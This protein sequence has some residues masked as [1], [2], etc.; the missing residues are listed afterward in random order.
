MKRFRKIYI[1]IN[2]VCNCKCVN[3]ILSEDSRV[4]HNELSINEIKDLVDS[5]PQIADTN[6]CN[7]AEVSGG[8]PTLH[9]NFI[10]ILQVLKSAKDNGALYK[11]ALLTNGITSANKVFCRNT[12]QYIDDVVITLYDTEPINHDWFTNV[13]GSLTDK[14]AAID[15]FIE[16]GVNVHIKLLVIKPSYQRLPEIAKYIIQRWGNKVHVAINGTHYT[17]DAHKNNELLFVKNQDAK[18]YIEE[19]LDL[20]IIN[21]ITVSVFFPLCVLD[22]IYWQY[23][24]RGFKD[25]IDASLSISPKY[26]IGKAERLLDEFIHRND[27]CATCLLVER[28]N[29]PW[30][31]YCEICN[32]QEIIDAR[33]KMYNNLII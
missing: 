15:N 5:I 4:V 16:C 13:P 14:A 11:I 31:R 27:I 33:T 32:E 9:R 6:H 7:I 18:A 10:E 29:W 1:N 25:V 30:K 24:P 21:K 8:E 19:A 20:L 17:G 2:S 23:S 3:C 26:K 22:P 28:C 12:S